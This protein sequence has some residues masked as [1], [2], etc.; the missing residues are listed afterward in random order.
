MLRFVSTFDMFF[1][2]HNSTRKHHKTLSCNFVGFIQHFDYY[3]STKQRL[4]SWF[5]FFNKYM[6]IHST[7]CLPSCSGSC[8]W[9]LPA[10]MAS[11]HPL[12]LLAVPPV[13]RPA[14]GHVSGCYG[15]LWPCSHCHS[16]A[17]TVPICR[18]SRVC[19]RAMS[20]IKLDLI[21]EN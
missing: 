4:P 10:S 16:C 3:K 6:F 21:S 20:A 7:T 13:A 15:R 9:L 8:F 1:S 19:E 12:C 11:L 17:G 18:I 2:R 14:R 5:P